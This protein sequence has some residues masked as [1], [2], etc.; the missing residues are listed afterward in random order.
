[1]RTNRNDDPGQDSWEHQH[2]NESKKMDR[3]N[4]DRDDDWN[5]ILSPGSNDESQDM[6]SDNDDF[7]DSGWDI[8]NKHS[9]S[10]DSRNMQSAGTFYKD[11]TE[12]SHG[13]YSDTDLNR[14]TT[15]YNRRNREEME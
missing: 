11:E 15:D 3:F 10:E 6:R 5:T 12:S 7:N 14:Y 4:K 1:M 2:E 13:R 9:N 8:D